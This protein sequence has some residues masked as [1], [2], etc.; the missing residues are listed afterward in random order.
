MAKKETLNPNRA[1]RYTDEFRDRAVNMYRDS[2]KSGVNLY[3]LRPRI[4]REL[5]IADVT[6]RDW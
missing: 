5:G 2:L 6:L 3:G 4:A 1:R